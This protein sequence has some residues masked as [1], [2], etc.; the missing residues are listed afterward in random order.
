MQ[1]AKQLVSLGIWTVGTRGLGGKGEGERGRGGEEERVGR[2][3]FDRK[4]ACVFTL[5]KA[6]F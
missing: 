3:A 2:R 5:P 6:S 4:E 1:I